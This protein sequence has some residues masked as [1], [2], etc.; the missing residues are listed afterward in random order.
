MN[1]KKRLDKIFSLIRKIDSIPDVQYVE[2]DME[3]YELLIKPNYLEPY[4]NESGELIDSFTLMPCW[5]FD[6]LKINGKKINMEEHI[7]KVKESLNKN[8]N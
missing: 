1:D 7:K 4:I 6:M 5:I 8:I 2:L 3:L